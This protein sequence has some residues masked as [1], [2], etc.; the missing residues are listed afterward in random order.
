MLPYAIDIDLG[1]FQLSVAVKKV[2]LNTTIDPATFEMPKPAEAP[3][4]AI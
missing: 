1:Q 3:K 2:E 4:P